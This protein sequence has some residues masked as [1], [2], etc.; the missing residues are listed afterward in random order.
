L[1]NFIVFPFDFQSVGS[2]LSF[3]LTFFKPPLKPV[4]ELSK[5]P[6]PELE[7]ET[8]GGGGGGGLL[9]ALLIVLLLLELANGGGL[10]V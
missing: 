1:I 5:S 9:F 2:L 3:V 10:R 6:L 4:I 7:L 8:G